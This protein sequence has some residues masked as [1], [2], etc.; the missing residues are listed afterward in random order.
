MTTR[1][2]HPSPTSTN[3]SRYFASLGALHDFA[4][5]LIDF[6]FERQSLCDPER[7]PY[8]FECLQVIAEHRSTEQLHLKV[9][10]LASQDLVS[11]RDL[12]VA[13]DTLRIDPS[14]TDE[15]VLNLYYVWI[16]DIGAE[17]QE[18]A[19]QALYKIGLVRGSQQLINTAQRVM[20]TYEDALQWLGN[21][22]DKATP[23][24]M[25]LSIVPIKV[26]FD[27]HSLTLQVH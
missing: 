7:R 25:L 6:A 20:E 11:R 17:A 18:N 14:E 3:S 19:R 4:D 12:K 16:S 21:G 9:A 5:G 22:V 8:Y 24:D 10:T 15:R 26:S 2:R 23:D 27:T 13:Y 1:N